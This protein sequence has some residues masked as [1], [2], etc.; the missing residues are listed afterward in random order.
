MRVGR[1]ASRASTAK[2]S[3]KFC[4]LPADILWGSF[5]TYSF[6]PLGRS[7]G[8]PGKLEVLRTCSYLTLYRKLL[9]CINE[10]CKSH[11]MSSL[12]TFVFFLVSLPPKL[13]ELALLKCSRWTYTIMVMAWNKQLII[14]C[15]SDTFC[16]KNILSDPVRNNLPPKYTLSKNGSQRS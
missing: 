3:L 12:A 14:L 11:V 10:H 2:E 7:V 6:F 1:A 16:Q 13:R 9:K 5:V 8:K 15:K 4:S